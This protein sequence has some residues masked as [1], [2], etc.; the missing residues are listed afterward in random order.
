MAT[1][2]AAALFAVSLVYADV[3]IT[4][5]NKDVSLAITGD[6]SMQ[7]GQAVHYFYKDLNEYHGQWI[8]QSLLHLGIDALYNKNLRIKIGM[9]GR[10]W[11]SLPDQSGKTTG[12]AYALY[13][14]TFTYSLYEACGTYLFENLLGMPVAA[15]LSVTTGLFR[16]KYNPDVRNLGE[17]LFRSYAYPAVL[18][19]YFDQTDVRLAG[20]KVSADVP[21]ADDL[22][23]LH[24][25][26]MLTFETEMYPFFDATPSFVGSCAVGNFLNVGFGVS[27]F[28][29]WPMNDSLTRP[30][31]DPKSMYRDGGYAN[32]YTYAGTKLM[33]RC[34]FDPKGLFKF[35]DAEDMVSLFGDEDLK[36]YSEAAVLGLESY[37]ANDTIGS[38]ATGNNNI[39]GYDTLAHK[40]PVLIGFN[41]PGFRVLDLMSLELEWYGCTYPM[42][43]ANAVRLGN[44]Y[45]Y[46]IPAEYNKPL[47]WYTSDNWKWSLYLKK[48]L[49][50]GHCSIIMQ[51]ARDHLRFQHILD[52]PKVYE[53]ALVRPNNWWW[54][55]KISWIF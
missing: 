46:P 32:F 30:Q 4:T 34:S 33:A 55:T 7:G 37:P 54:T 2:T 6:A 39:W 42:N 52:E 53:E 5:D 49:A 24:G 48:T 22:I 21:L 26:L 12:Q 41:I 18:V 11:F 16:Y 36:V 23:K 29:L 50:N 15:S 13:D 8:Q 14:K 43:L 31:T 19:N 35:F 3:K 27:L 1:T 17:Y 51:F 25:D 9:E 44:Q 38:A 28:H 47:S 45:A 10:L 40:I 20:F